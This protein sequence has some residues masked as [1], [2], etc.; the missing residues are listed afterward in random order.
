MNTYAAIKTKTSQFTASKSIDEYPEESI[1]KIA[2]LF[3]DIVSSSE[4]FKSYGDA[5]GRKMLRRHQELASPAIIEHG[6]VVVKIL[7]DSIMAY[8]SSPQ[9][10]LKSAYDSGG[11]IPRSSK[12]VL[13]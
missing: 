7:G 3:T 8:F 4:F 12:M 2:V 13:L 5:A 11:V 1:T 6:G 10:A 9:E